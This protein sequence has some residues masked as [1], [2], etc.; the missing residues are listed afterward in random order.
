MVGGVNVLFGFVSELC[1][2]EWY[3]YVLSFKKNYWLK[4]ISLIKIIELLK[5]YLLIIKIVL[6][7]I[8]LF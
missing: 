4:K 1:K 2:M 5:N 7:V 3:V 6:I 8:L